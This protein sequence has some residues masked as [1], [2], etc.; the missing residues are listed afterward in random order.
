MN[1][2]ALIPARKNSK[3]IKNKNIINFFGKPLIFYSINICHKIKLISEVFVS[4]DSKK[5]QKIGIKNEAKCPF[6]RPSN[7]SKDNSTDLEVFKHFYKFYLKNY[8][9]KI[10]LLLHIRPTTPLRSSALLE[11]LI[12]I[13]IKNSK[14]SSLRCFK[15][16]EKSPYKMWKKKGKEAKPL[17]NTKKEL[18]STARQTHPNVYNHVGYLDIIRP[19][20]TLLRN[21]MVGKK[22]Y[23]YLLDPN[24]HYTNDID[25]KKDLITDKKFLKFK[26]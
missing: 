20:K 2:V 13:M 8:K 16:S 4:T 12:K 11:K 17:F 19:E 3:G 25:T 18:H 24:I 22:V 6:I 21:S 10:D 5:I 7:I 23:F 9:K 1:I 15:L 26:N 14:F